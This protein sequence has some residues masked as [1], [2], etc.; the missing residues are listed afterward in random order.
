MFG[1][2]DE[3]INKFANLAKYSPALPLIGG[4]KTKFQPVYVNDIAKSVAKIITSGNKY[5]HATYELGGP[6][7]LSFA[8]I[9]KLIL[10]HSKQPRILYKLPFCVAN[11][12]ALF[13]EFMPKPILTRDQ[14]KLLKCDNLTQDNALTF[15]DLQIQPK[16]IEEIIPEYLEIYQS[17]CYSGES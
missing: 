13:F 8:E 7:I 2:E 5:T 10:L 15:F 3:F 1:A 16:T 9:I 17:K 12:L 4:G 14:L 11:F 6:D